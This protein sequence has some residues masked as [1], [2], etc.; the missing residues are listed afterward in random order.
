MVCE[1]GVAFRI[2]ELSDDNTD[3]LLTDA[4]GHQLALF[5]H[6][7]LVPEDWASAHS[8]GGQ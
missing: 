7:R 4:C 6:S 3:S 8:L 5:A 2:E 1:A